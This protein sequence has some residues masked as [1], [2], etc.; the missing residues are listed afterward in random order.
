M[1]PPGIRSPQLEVKGAP[2]LSKIRLFSALISSLELFP[3]TAREIV[4]DTA[5][6]HLI[7]PRHP[8]PNCTLNRLSQ[9]LC[10]T[11]VASPYHFSPA[12]L[13]SLCHRF[14]ISLH[15]VQGE[16]D[17]RRVTYRGPNPEPVSSRK[18]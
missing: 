3:Y 1:N 5:I 16:V 11:V 17:A 4:H 18:R 9:K 14:P 10:Q 2:T 8:G 6:R 12:Q 13:S 15:N 7:S